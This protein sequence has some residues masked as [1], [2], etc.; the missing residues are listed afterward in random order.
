MPIACGPGSA[1]DKAV[2][3]VLYIT[4]DGLTDDIG[5]SQILPYLN[6]CADAGHSLTIIS[7]EKRERFAASGEC[8]LRSCE[9]RGMNW[10]PQRFR[11]NPPLLSKWLDVRTMLKAAERAASETKF[12]LVHARSYPAAS[13]GLSL[14][15][16]SGLK[17]LF[18]MRG[19]WPD[20]RREGGRWRPGSPIG[21]LLFRS[22]K[23]KE[24]QILAAA[25]HVITLTEQ[26]K[27]I[28]E[29]WGRGSAPISVVPCCADFNVYRVARESDR[30]NARRELGISDGAPVIGYLGSLGT[31]YRLH[32]HLRLFVALRQQIATATMLFVS[33]SDAASILSVAKLH[34]LEIGPH[35]LR[36]VSGSRDEVS[37]WISA[38]DV[39]T[40]FCT[41]SFSSAGISATKLAEYLACG[42]P[43]IGNRHVGDTERILGEVN[44]GSLVSDFSDRSIKSA[45]EAL[46]HLLGTDRQALRERARPLLDLPRAISAYNSIYDEIA[47]G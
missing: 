31:V 5:Q 19:F 34:S 15:R 43:V 18:D 13:V 2:A 26:A 44:G 23:S 14:K 25:D 11:S 41:P 12:D 45:T 1:T 42:V 8:V 27:S 38:M 16:Q 6:G 7:F 22:W 4:Y 37:Q 47:S 20:Q 3:K 35:D 30:L 17:L 40:C 36:V 39:G 10:Q 9:R 28:V 32:D 33:R 24:V 21:E 29:A 46:I